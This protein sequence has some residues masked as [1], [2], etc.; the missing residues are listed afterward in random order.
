MKF[1]SL[2]IFIVLWVSIVYAPIAHWVWGGGWLGDLGAL[3]FAG[4]TVVHISA[5]AGALVSALIIG[6]RIGF[7][8]QPMGP[9]NVPMVILGAAL[10]WFGWFGFNI[11]T[12]DSIGLNAINTLL[13]GATGAVVALYIRLTLTGKTDILMACNGALAG[14]VGVTAPV[15]FVEPWAAVVIG[16][17]AAPIMMASVSF[18]DKVLTANCWVGSFPAYRFVKR[19]QSHNRH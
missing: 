4:G 2:C 19:F 18:I 5:G 17:I 6:R 15:A 11:N 3:D 7:P 8:E 14:L 13:A 12:G 10:L 9:A 1:G 16:A